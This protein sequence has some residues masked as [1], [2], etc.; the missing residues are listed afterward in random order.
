MGGIRATDRSM[1]GTVVGDCSGTPWWCGEAKH[2]EGV[3]SVLL[4]GT[5][6]GRTL[7]DEVTR[8]LD[9][10]GPSSWRIVP[11]TPWYTAMPS[12]GRA[13]ERIG[14]PWRLHLS[15]APHSAPAILQVV[16]PLLAQR[17]LPFSFAP[18]VEHVRRLGGQTCAPSEFGI[19]LSTSPVENDDADLLDLARLL[20]VA[21]LGLPGPRI[22]HAWPY[23]HGSIVHMGNG[24][25]D[26]AADVLAL[27]DDDGL[28]YDD[29][30]AGMRPP[31]EAR[32]G[33]LPRDRLTRDP[34]G[35]PALVE[36]DHSD[37]VVLP[38]A[39]AEHV[40]VPGDGPDGLDPLSGPAVRLRDR[41]LV[42]SALR[43]T[44]TGGI[45]VATDLAARPTP[46]DVLLKHARAHTDVDPDGSDARAR[47]LREAR[48]LH[49][50][51]RRVPVPRP[52]EV[53]A[54]AGDVFLVCESRPGLPL[55][56]WVRRHA[57][58]DGG[59]PA[60]AALLV[61]RRLMS[62]LASVHRA[63][64]VLRNL[65]PAHIVVGTD[66]WPT[67]ADVSDATPLGRIAPSRGVR[68]YRAPELHDPDAAVPATTAQDLF[69]LGAL[70]FLLATGSDPV[71]P[72]DDTAERRPVRERLASWLGL[73]ARYSDTARLFA[74]A[75]MTLLAEDPQERGDL[76]G[77][78]RL[79]SA[80]RT[81]APS[82]P[83]VSHPSADALLADGLEY[84]VA[85]MRPDEERL[86]PTGERGRR[87]DPR[88]VQHGAAGVLS[89][90]LRA[91]EHVRPGEEAPVCVDAAARK[92]ASWLADRCDRGDRLVPGL[93]FGL[94][95]VAWVLADAAVTL[96]EPQLRAHAEQLTLRLPTS[97]PVPGV[98]H[99]L[100]GAALAHLHLAELSGVGTG[101]H[102]GGDGRFFERAARYAKALRAA[103]VPGPKGPTWPVPATARSR[104]AG[105]SHYGFAHGVA[106]IGY[107]LLC[108]GTALD[109]E[110]SITVAA[111]AGSALCRAA[112]SDD[113]GAAWWP[114]GPYD[115]TQLSHWCSGS[116][117]IGTFL[118]RLFAVTG[119]QRFG[120]YA[121]AAAGA[122]HR[123][124][125]TSSPAACHGL[126]GDSEFLLD[127]ATWLADPTYR[128]W[129]EDLVPLIAARHCR[130]QGRVLLPD[131]TL[132]GVV[133]DYGVG[134]S[135]VLAYLLRLRHGGGRAFLLDDLLAEEWPE[136]VPELAVPW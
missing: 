65:D 9:N 63:G 86:W 46:V 23:R 15:A 80:A 72:D 20:H 45:Y 128:A 42:T 3:R 47:L 69:G 68:E 75:I 73:V 97:W 89:V 93:H 134:L 51:A 90:L 59:V 121:R 105:T 27:L 129:A 1:C 95:G 94:A 119:E 8:L 107:A 31:Y 52:L 88:A 83:P 84:L 55:R 58:T 100:A 54:N 125:W 48:T 123:A 131:E 127:A 92:A 21:T 113:D 96:G 111:E 22:P 99:G 24:G 115:A 110:A 106:G 103:A 30:P 38:E 5:T 6:Q 29:S 32:H 118:L 34:T 25:L 74:P 117:G 4:P 13:S 122:V 57:G 136:A 104:L 91:R 7:A 37:R 124:R 56:Q 41:Y 18:T 50:L 112:R 44:L 19:F 61:A 35:S 14:R 11:G 16:V 28:A 120:E 66:G 39:S 85:T 26:P 79:L 43:A 64:Y 101:G 82:P 87:A 12:S 53:F 78:S 135:G 62:M 70:L 81:T 17:D 132:R 77:A 76:P 2:R 49:H 130:R 98:A 36:R 33:R 116:S 102:R 60:P 109:D 40:P 114:V 67:L 10:S 108:L 126:A 133:A 71:L